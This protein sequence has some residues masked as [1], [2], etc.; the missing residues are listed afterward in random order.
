MNQ[1][2]VRTPGGFGG[3]RYRVRPGRIG[4]AWLN[5]S[6]SRLDAPVLA[7]R[8]AVTDEVIR[9]KRTAATADQYGMT[10]ETN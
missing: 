1:K 10:L 6:L 3:A 8:D 5:Q 9:Q 2:S 4:V 7:A